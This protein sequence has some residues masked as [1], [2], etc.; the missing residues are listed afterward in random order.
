MLPATFRR[1]FMPTIRDLVRALRQRDGVEAVVVLGRD[2]LV[3]EALAAPGV[4]ADGLAAL[5]P[6]VAAAAH[7]L[8]AQQDAGD[9]VTAVLEY[10][11]RVAIA[12]ILSHD[13]ILVVLADA[14]AEVGPLLH[15]LRR[16]RGRIAAIV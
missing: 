10:E 14:S 1:V 12:S 13:V 7:D 15:E 6:T 8:G 2:G 11:R 16:N 3:I 9:L 4:E 5:V